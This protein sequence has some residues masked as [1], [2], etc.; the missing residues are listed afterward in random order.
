MK[1]FIGMLAALLLGVTCALAESYTIDGATVQFECIDFSGELTEEAEDIFSALLREGDEIHSG[2]ICRTYYDSQPGVLQK[3][4]ALMALLREGKVLLMSA[5]WSDGMW[6]ACVETD[7]F[8]AP[9]TEF[10]ITTLPVYGMEDLSRV[11]PSIRCGNESYRLSMSTGGVVNIQQYVRLAADGS[12]V[13]MEPGLGG[14]VYRVYQ[15][16]ERTKSETWYDHG[17]SPTRLC[18]WTMENF[19]KTVAEAQIFLL[20]HVPD[21]GEDEAFLCGGNFRE[22]PTGASSSMGKYSAKAQ[23]LGS[24]MGKSEPWYNV[25]VGDLTGW[26][27]GNYVV[28]SS[29]DVVNYYGC[30]SGVRKVARAN[31]TL[32]LR[33]LPDGEAVATVEAG[34]LMHVIIENEGWVHVIVPRGEISWLTDWDGM[35]GFVRTDEVTTGVSIA[36]MMW[37]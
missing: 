20:D 36:D 16:G 31:S 34:T 1:R 5:Y 3:Q 24:Q 6:A 37:K 26:V 8:I 21:L 2:T 23:I 18:A 19:P 15:E 30:A 29:Y 33:N 35:Y 11:F 22:R 9:G 28:Q 32:T 13:T 4:S 7:S 17:V 10:E 25:R 27:S 14:F 12:A